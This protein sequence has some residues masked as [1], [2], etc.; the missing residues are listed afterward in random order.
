MTSSFDPDAAAHPEAGLFGLRDTSQSAGIHVIP[1]P[2]DATTSYRK[3]T[4]HGPRAVFEASRQVEL[5]DRRFGRP[6]EAG[7]AWVEDARIGQW[8]EEASRLSAP[9]IEAGGHDLEERFLRGNLARIDELGTAV[10][11]SVRE[12]AQAALA[13]DRVPIVLGGDHA[14]P[15]GA[16]QACAERHPGLGILHVDAHADLREAFEGFRWSHASIF[17]NVLE[18]VPGVARLHQVGIRDCG[19]NELAVIERDERIVAFFDD[20]WSGVALP[21]RPVRPRYDAESILE[22]LPDDVYVSIDIDG[23]DPKLCPNTGTP[24][25]GGLEWHDVTTLLHAL[26]ASGRRV[27]GADLCEV[28]PGAGGDPRGESYDAIVGARLLYGLCGLVMATRR[29]R[30]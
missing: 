21:G 25:P 20:E 7:I 29:A 1:V 8:N 9:V 5:F 6:Y 22:G 28:S 18:Q 16:I 2:F 23:L 15:F 14:S 19:E 30:A 27:V 10:N 17:H 4:A 12:R 24:V 26:S 11:E 13:E 3:G